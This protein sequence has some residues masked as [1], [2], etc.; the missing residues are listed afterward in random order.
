MTNPLPKFFRRFPKPFFRINAGAQVSLRPKRTADPVPRATE[1]DIITTG[2][3]PSEPASIS[4]DSGG[5]SSSSSSFVSQWLNAATAEDADAPA[6]PR[7]NRRALLHEHVEPRI[8]R[9]EGGGK[10]PNGLR[11]RLNTAFTRHYFL[12]QWRGESPI[13]F[14][15]QEGECPL[16]YHPPPPLRITSTVFSNRGVYIGTPVPEDLVLVRPHPDNDEWF[17]EPARRMTLQGTPS[18]LPLLLPFCH[19]CESPSSP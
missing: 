5:G 2:L 3:Q 16:I 10:T 1:Y 4:S 17:L 7:V 11:L 6:A 18:P 9:A 13:V 8:R 14:A 15:V 12:R 19:P